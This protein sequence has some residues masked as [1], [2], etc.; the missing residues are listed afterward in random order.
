LEVHVISLI[1]PTLSLLL[2]LGLSPVEPGVDS[3]TQLRET[4]LHGE[5]LEAQGNA[6][7]ALVALKDADATGAL[8]SI[9]SQKR[10]P[11]LVRTWAA[12]GAVQRANSLAE[13]EALA[14]LLSRHPA[15][16]RPFRLSAME[17][18][19]TSLDPEALL[20]FSVKSPALQTAFS[21][22]LAQADVSAMMRVLFTHKDNAVRRLAAGY[23]ANRDAAA[24]SIVTRYRYSG[25][26]SAVPWAG[27]ALYVPALGW[28]R[29]QAK[30][31]LG[32]LTAWHLHCDRHGLT[33]EKQQ[34]FN[35]LMSV[36]IWRQAGSRNRPVNDT[37]KLLK[38][39]A[40]L[41]GVEKVAQLL[42]A[43]GVRHSPKYAGALEGR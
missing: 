42:Q 35:N 33:Q 20:T 6:I 25:S 24:D 7:L 19:G 8:I 16:E 11:E 3:V 9:E 13:L 37:V 43:Q 14:D 22:T 12:A 10:A 36:G 18:M 21:Q 5:T 26:G 40:G 38:Q 17:L 41:V 34:V 23:I 15:L 28:S 1:R 2:L 32:H 31:L 30:I 4:A 39:Y 27:G 29:A